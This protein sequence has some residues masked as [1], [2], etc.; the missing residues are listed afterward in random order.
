MWY[1][2]F[3]SKKKNKKE[4]FK[5]NSNLTKIE[6]ILELDWNGCGA[7]LKYKL[8][9]VGEDLYI[10]GTRVCALNDI[11]DISTDADAVFIEL[12]N[13]KQVV[14]YINWIHGHDAHICQIYTTDLMDEDGDNYEM[15]YN[16]PC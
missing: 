11:E 6:E 15:L 10:E 12:K 9:E 1:N 8:E 13:S 4:G 5:M 2:Q 14:V 7:N 3:K 16:A